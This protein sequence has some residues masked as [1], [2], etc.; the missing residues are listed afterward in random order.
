MTWKTERDA[1]LGRIAVLERENAMKLWLSTVDG[2]TDDDKL[3]NALSMVAQSKKMLCLDQDRD[4]TFTQTNRQMPQVGFRMDG[5]ALPGLNNPEIGGAVP[6]R[7][8]LNMNGPWWDT[9][10][11]AG[12]QGV[13]LQNFVVQQAD[14]AWFWRNN[15]GQSGHAPYPVNIHHTAFLG[16]KGVLGTLAEKFTAT[17]LSYTG[18]CATQGF[19]GT[20]YHIGG[21][22]MN[23]WPADYHNI[24]SQRDPGSSQPIIK[25]DFES[26]SNIGPVYMTCDGKFRGIEVDGSAGEQKGCALTINGGLRDEGHQTQIPSNGTLIRVRGGG[27]VAIENIKVA[28]P[29]QSPD[30]DE[31][32][33][34]QIEAGD[35]SLQGIFYDQGSWTG[36]M[37]YVSGGVLRVSN[38]KS[39]SGQPMIVKQAGGVATGDASVTI[40]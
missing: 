18:I 37:A 21:G 4:W 38:A 29:M 36:P 20:P 31:H 11:Q 10:D 14:G 35:V 24:E 16:G 25:L 34:V 6:F 12:V 7:I 8:H 28:W 23:L 15:Y 30:A 5:G 1:V 3:T 22:D 40:Q 39:I 13:T 19:L 26:N 27:T 32:G 2:A 17:Q 33:A 9:T